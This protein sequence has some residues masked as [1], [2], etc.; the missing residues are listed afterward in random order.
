M[1]VTS[2][3][4]GTAEGARLREGEEGEE[5]A[6]GIERIVTSRLR[7]PGRP[8]EVRWK[9]FEREVPGERVPS[10]RDSMTEVD[11]CESTRMRLSVCNR[12]S[13]CA[14]EE[15]LEEDAPDP[16]SLGCRKM[17]RKTWTSTSSSF[18][19]ST[20]TGNSSPR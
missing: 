16:S 4:E 8:R 18:L 2:A 7:G 1:R 11:D 20:L 5:D 12:E 13:Q 3:G 6:V 17:T 14:Q 19:T 10:E 15:S 9:V